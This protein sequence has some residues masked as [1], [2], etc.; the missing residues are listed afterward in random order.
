MVGLLVDDVLEVVLSL[1]APGLEGVHLLVEALVGGLGDLVAEEAVG[2][3][4]DGDEGREVEPLVLEDE[5]LLGE[6]EGEGAA[7]E[8]VGPRH[9]RLVVEGREPGVG[10]E[11][12]ADF[13]GV[14]R[15]L[16]VGEVGRVSL[17]ELLE[18]RR[19]GLPGP[20][21]VVARVP[22]VPH[23]LLRRLRGLHRRRRRPQRRQAQR[24]PIPTLFSKGRRGER[25]GE[26]GCG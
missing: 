23:R 11:A 25:D 17:R 8:C 1:V 16:R 26:P 22:L 13:G 2:E 19:H 14:E 6:E 12:E 21:P 24:L 9:A 5:P 7:A 15:R 4:D 10:D 20:L 18:V 3:P